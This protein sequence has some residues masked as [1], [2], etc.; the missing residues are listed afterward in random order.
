MQVKSRIHLTE[1][2]QRGHA[3]YMYTPGRFMLCAVTKREQG[4]LPDDTLRAKPCFYFDPRYL[5]QLHQLPQGILLNDKHHDTSQYQLRRRKK[6][7]L[8]N[9]RTLWG[10]LNYTAVVLWF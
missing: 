10:R 5:R 4:F 3:T 8:I 7:C 6:H 2:S 9:E 1:M